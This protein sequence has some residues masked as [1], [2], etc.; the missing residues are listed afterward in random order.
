MLL[1]IGGFVTINIKI[2]IL[3]KSDV[4]TD[5]KQLLLTHVDGRINI[6]TFTT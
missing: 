5:H 4:I 3:Y 6:L 2:Y 1:I